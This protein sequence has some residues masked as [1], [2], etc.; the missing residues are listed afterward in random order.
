MKRGDS[1][2][3]TVE[4]TTVEGKSVG[5]VEGLAVFIKGG[6]PGDF[7]RARVNSVKKNFAECEVAEILRPSG[8]R[9][10]PQCR[11]FGICGGCR[12]QQV[13]YPAQLQF[14]R[15]HVVDALERLGGF[16]GIAVEQAVGVTDPYFYRNKMEFSFGERWQTIEELS[17]GGTGPEDRFGLGLHVAG[18]YDRVVDVQEC[19]LQSTLSAS[20]V[21]SVRDFCK[22]RGLQP[23]APRTHEGYL[24]NLVIREGRR[25]GEVMVNIVTRDDRPDVMTALSGYLR[26]AFPGITTIINNI[27]A[28]VSQVAVGEYEKTYFGKGT[29]SEK[30]GSRMYRIS[31]NSF[32]QTNTEQAERLYD[33]A[34]SFAGLRRE[35]I[36]YDLYAGTGTIA[37][38]VAD[39]ASHVFGIEAVASAVEDARRNAGDNHVENCTFLL[40]D[41]KETLVGSRQRGTPLPRPD[42]VLTDP[43]RVGMHEKVVRELLALRPRTIVYI[44]CNPST[45]ARDLKVLCES[46]TYA[47]TRVQPI[48]MFPHTSHIENIT[49]LKVIG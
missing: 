1:I 18:R 31:A 35:D 40:G 15:Q 27:T 10:E 38:H 21:N 3:V 32:F 48:D 43:P 13:Q 45:Q 19:W 22:T 4:S 49:L 12:W 23:Y 42:V 6:V 37:L 44:S 8:L 16:P 25:T 11:H 28:R 46:G 36:V 24:R 26:S 7:L 5:H 2:E 30:I 39:E 41:L 47:I 34:K 33:V 17:T 9:T 20:I 14:K 29:I